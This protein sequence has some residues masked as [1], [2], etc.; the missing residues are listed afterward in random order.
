M[1]QDV[2]IYYGGM[3]A[4]TVSASKTCSVIMSRWVGSARQEGLGSNLELTPVS[5]GPGTMRP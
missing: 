3:G 5:S 1:V 2:S 4:T